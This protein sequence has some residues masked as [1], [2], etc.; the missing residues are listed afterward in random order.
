[1]WEGGRVSGRGGVTAQTPGG[2]RS[3]RAHR[4]THGILYCNEGR[5]GGGSPVGGES[6]GCVCYLSCQCVC[7]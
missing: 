6:R 3:Q 5:R 7:V 2:G 1:M 4:I